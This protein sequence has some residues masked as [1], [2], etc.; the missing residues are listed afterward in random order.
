MKE[1]I[2][3]V[4][5]RREGFTMAEL[6]IVVAIIA[7]LV[8]IAIPVFTAQLEKSKEATDLANIR[9]AYAEIVAEKLTTDNS[10]A[11]KSVAL[12][13]GEKSWQTT[14]VKFPEN[15]YTNG[16]KSTSGTTKATKSNTK[17]TSSKNSKAV[18]TPIKNGVMIKIE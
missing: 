15:V 8:A 3:K 5:E 2:K 14:D 1:M 7:V 18:I 9:T 16:T 10:V 6:L 17:T 11:A 12:T 13:Q 4:K